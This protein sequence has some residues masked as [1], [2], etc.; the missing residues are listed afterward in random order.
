MLRASGASTKQANRFKGANPI[1]ILDIIN[2][3]DS[4]AARLAEQYDEDISDIYSGMGKS[5]KNAED[6]FDSP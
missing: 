2:K 4:T 1:K 3:Y 6:I 5:S